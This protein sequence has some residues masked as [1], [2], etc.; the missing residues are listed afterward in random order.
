MGCLLHCIIANQFDK[1][2]LAWTCEF[3]TGACTTLTLKSTRRKRVS[4]SYPILTRGFRT[5]GKAD[6]TYYS[7]V[8]DRNFKYL[9]ARRDHG[10]KISQLARLI[11]KHGMRVSTAMLQEFY[12]IGPPD[13]LQSDNGLEFRNETRKGEFILLSFSN[14]STSEVELLMKILWLGKILVKAMPKHS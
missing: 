9:L 2:M 8:P 3:H 13:M 11:Y 12:C 6:L 14:E 4:R 10:T 7:S 5:R 1:R